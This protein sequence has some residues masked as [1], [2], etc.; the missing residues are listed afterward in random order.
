MPSVDSES[1]EH[2]FNKVEP[3]KLGT[4]TIYLIVLYSTSVITKM[5]MHLERIYGVCWTVNI[6]VFAGTT[7]L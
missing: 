2:G 1:T 6:S 7:F 3:K 5:F 4:E